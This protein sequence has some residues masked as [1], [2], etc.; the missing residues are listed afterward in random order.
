M[1]NDELGLVKGATAKIH[2]NP[3]APPRFCKPRTVP[4]TLRQKVQQKLER[5][6]EAKIIEQEEFSEWEAPIVPVIK[7]D[8]SV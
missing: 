7:Q 6:E 2:I 4:Y 8:G 5:L 3:Q 1:F